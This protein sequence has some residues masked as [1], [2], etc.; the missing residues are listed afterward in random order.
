MGH[1]VAAG[2]GGAHDGGVGD[3]GAVIP[4]D[5][6]GAH[7]R[8]RHGQQ[9]TSG[10]H[11]H[12]HGNENAHGA[13]AGAGG[14]GQ[15]P[16]HQKQGQGE[17]GRQ[18]LPAVKQLPDKGRRAQPGGKGLQPPGKGQHQQ[19]R[20]D[21]LEPVQKALHK[22]GKAH[23]P[24]GDIQQGHHQQ[25]DGA[26]EAQGHGGVGVGKDVG[27]RQGQARL[28]AA[29]AAQHRHAPHH[30]DDQARRGQQQV[31][32][33]APGA[34]PAL[35]R[36]L[37]PGRLLP[38]GQLLPAVHGAEIPAR[39]GHQ[40]HQPQHQQ[41]IEIIR[42]GLNKQGEAV[43]M[44][45]IR[46][47]VRRHGGGPGADGGQDAHRG[48]GGV[49][50]K[51]QL[52]P[53]DPAAV[54]DGLHDGPHRQAVEVV[55]QED[56]AAQAR[57]GRYRPPAGPHPAGG[58]LP[59]GPGAAGPGKQHHNGPQQHVKEED[60]QVDALHQGQEQGLKA[61]PGG[62][63]LRQQC[64]HHA[65]GQQGGI[66]L[67]G[68]KGQHNGHRRRQQRPAGGRKRGRAA[69]IGKGDGAQQHQRRR[70][71]RPPPAEGSFHGQYPHFPHKSAPRRGRP[72]TMSVCGS[73]TGIFPGH[74]P[75]VPRCI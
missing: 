56:Q 53:G 40:K 49:D 48:G 12:R 24:P 43:D 11:R 17:Q 15:H 36:S 28:P 45:V 21:E 41:G 14:K 26:A 22:P 23:D 25:G 18:G 69:A 29:A 60:L 52:L 62:K 44:A 35:R 42:Y 66:H 7:R 10:K 33:P 3:G 61:A 2:S 50:D 46:R 9:R 63:A 8:H 38:E 34:V 27:G 67:L 65:P 47:D 16:A 54:G 6:P 51:G 19:R 59:E 31:H 72:L 73:M 58:P 70:Q 55:V 74:A 71:H 39:Q 13:P 20:G 4:H 37:G 5:G 64:S 30:R 1:V 68:G 57:R 32:R 75:S